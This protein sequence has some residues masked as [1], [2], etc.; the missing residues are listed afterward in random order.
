MAMFK[1][2]ILT[3]ISPFLILINLFRMLLELVSSE[4]YIFW[5]V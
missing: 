5:W 3:V 2:V 4:N 1:I